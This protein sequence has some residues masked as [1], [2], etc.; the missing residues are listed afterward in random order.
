M[1]SLCDGGGAFTFGS[2]F[3]ILRIVPKQ[4]LPRN[5]STFVFA[6]FNNWIRV[7][8]VPGSVVIDV[9]RI[10][11]VLTLFESRGGIVLEVVV[12]NESGGVP[13]GGDGGNV[14][15][16]GGKVGSN[17]CIIGVLGSGLERNEGPANERN[18][19]VRCPPKNFLL[20]TWW[21]RS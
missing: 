1:R 19:F 20:C 9:S 12:V 13:C 15:G 3:I 5:A 10:V 11:L 18:D 7:F 17:G 21:S 4:Y 6:C 2:M 8:V 16:L 14:V